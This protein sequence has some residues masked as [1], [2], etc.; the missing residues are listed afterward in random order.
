MNYKLDLV[1]ARCAWL[2]T[3]IKIRMV[4]ALRLA[5]RREMVSRPPEKHALQQQ[6]NLQ[7]RS[8][9]QET[10]DDSE[11]HSP[12]IDKTSQVR[13]Y[14][15]GNWACRL[16]HHRIGSHRSKSSRGSLKY[17]S[18]SLTAGLS[19]WRY[20]AVKDFFTDPKV[21]GG[22][23]DGEATWEELEVEDGV[24]SPELEVTLLA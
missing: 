16:T 12:G 5:R 2:L 10:G 20:Q 17:S 21:D 9:G 18:S 19:F 22:D 7:H 24:V 4:F 11:V 6:Q 13:R 3:S 1:W 23:R 14:K 8:R 15:L